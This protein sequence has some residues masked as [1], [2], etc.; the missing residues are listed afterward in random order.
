MDKILFRKT[1]SMVSPHG[2]DEEGIGSTIIIFY[3]KINV[4]LLKKKL[5]SNVD[6][7]GDADNVITARR[8]QR[9]RVPRR[10]CGAAHK[11]ES[12]VV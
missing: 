7:V 12:A 5:G 6:S 9:W 3:H 1:G 11:V 8:I 10:G 4:V 2:P